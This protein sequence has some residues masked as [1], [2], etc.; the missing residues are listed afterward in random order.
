MTNSEGREKCNDTKILDFGKAE[1]P[2]LTFY[3]SELVS[4]LKCIFKKMDMNITPVD[5]SR[6][7]KTSPKTSI[8]YLIFGDHG[9]SPIVL[10]K[11]FSHAYN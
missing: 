4:L 10:L 11:D 8:I 3:A 5:R 7:E 2:L 9:N 1:C 6:E